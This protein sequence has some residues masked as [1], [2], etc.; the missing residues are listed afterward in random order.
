M[1]VLYS[2]SKL[3][4]KQLAFTMPTLFLELEFYLIKE[5]TLLIMCPEGPYSELLLVLHLLVEL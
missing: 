5:N 1:Q 3:R 2:L 4:C